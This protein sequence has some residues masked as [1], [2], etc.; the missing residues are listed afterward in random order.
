MKGNSLRLARKILALV[1]LMAL[2]IYA[3]AGPLR[4]RTNVTGLLLYH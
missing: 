3:K 4:P 2:K 1:K